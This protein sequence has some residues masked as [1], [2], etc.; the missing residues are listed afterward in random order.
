[1]A[2]NTATVN[3]TLKSGEDSSRPDVLL[4]IEC[5]AVLACTAIRACIEAAPNKGRT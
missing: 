2:K 1:M 5:V 3:W 4:E